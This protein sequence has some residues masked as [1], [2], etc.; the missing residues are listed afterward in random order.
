[1]G[2][3]LALA[4]DTILLLSQTDSRLS[5]GASRPWDGDGEDSLVGRAIIPFCQ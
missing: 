4:L 1:M 5:D 2:N 3:A